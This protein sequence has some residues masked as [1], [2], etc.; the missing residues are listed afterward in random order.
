MT[1]S[2]YLFYLKQ[3]CVFML[4]KNIENAIPE[5][6]KKITVLSSLAYK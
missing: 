6:L 5:K 4:S 3:M 1:F 2:S